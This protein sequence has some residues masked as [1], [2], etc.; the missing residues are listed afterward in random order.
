MYC[1]EVRKTKMLLIDDHIIGVEHSTTFHSFIRSMF[2]RVFEQTEKHCS[3]QKQR[4]IKLLVNISFIHIS[5]MFS[6]LS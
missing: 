6:Y 4:V 3:V 2:D 1:T 5:S